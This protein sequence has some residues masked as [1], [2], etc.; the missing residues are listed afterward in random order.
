MNVNILVLISSYVKIA[1]IFQ[2]LY[3]VQFMQIISNI[4]TFVETG[5]LHFKHFS[6]FRLF[7][8]FFLE[9]IFKHIKRKTL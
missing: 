6:L 7:I 5:P 1:L 8:C 9:R 2:N 4:L 3:D